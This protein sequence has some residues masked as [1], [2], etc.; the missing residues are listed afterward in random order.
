MGLIEPSILS[1][2]LL[3]ASSSDPL[4]DFLNTLGTLGTSP[5]KMVTP[6]CPYLQSPEEGRD[7]P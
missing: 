6:R 1:N 5:Y 3:G 7:S 4:D 2:T